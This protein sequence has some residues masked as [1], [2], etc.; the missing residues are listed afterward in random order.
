MKNKM[1]FI[2]K[3]MALLLAIAFA[4]TLVPSLSFKAYAADNAQVKDIIPTKARIYTQSV[5][6]SAIEIELVDSGY[7][8]TKLKS[9][10]KNLKVYNTGFEESQ[11][12]DYKTEFQIGCYALKSGT[13]KVS[14][15][16]VKG[17][18]KTAKT[19]TV[20]AKDDSPIK[21]VKYGGKRLDT[22]NEAYYGGF[23]YPNSGAF[24]VT[25]NKGYKLKRIEVERYIKSSYSSDDYE[26]VTSDRYEIKNGATVTLSDQ[27]YRHKYESEYYPENAEDTEYMCAETSFIVHYIDKYT[28]E[29]RTRSYS[30]YKLVNWVH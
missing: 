23:G 13:Y 22:Y 28:K 10:D 9:S 8:L 26:G 16:L 17:K 25:M 6:N 4:V 14:F 18:K 20:Y 3:G 11:Y 12:G 30:V 2:R 27:A 15:T 29:E 7:K 21:S 5:D 1:N 24:K 19:V